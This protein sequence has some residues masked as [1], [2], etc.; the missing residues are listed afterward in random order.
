MTVTEDL[1]F[2]LL[3]RYKPSTHNQKQLEI[4]YLAFIDYLACLSWKL[5]RTK[6][7]LNH[8]VC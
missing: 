5:Q 6:R 3:K 7:L 4:A 1:V 2:H 8:S